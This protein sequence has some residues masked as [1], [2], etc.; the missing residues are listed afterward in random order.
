MIRKC[1]WKYNGGKIAKSILKK[2]HKFGGL[3]LPDSS[4]CCICVWVSANRVLFKF[5][6]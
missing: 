1:I 4:K 2:E 5:P 6:P 3:M